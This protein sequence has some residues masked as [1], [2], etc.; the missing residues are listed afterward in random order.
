MNLTIIS[1]THGKHKHITGD[2]PGG[3]LLLHAGYLSSGVYEHEIA[4][5]AK[6]IILKI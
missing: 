3:D 2:L 1:D 5:F 6:L 4:Q